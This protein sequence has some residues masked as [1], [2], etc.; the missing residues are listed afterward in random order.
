[1]DPAWGSASGGME[2]PTLF[3]G[4]TYLWAPPPLFSPESVTIHEA[5]HQF[6]YGLVGNNEF[7]EAW[8]DEGF[9]TYHTSKA[10]F[11]AL[12][13]RG[14]GHRYFGPNLGRGTRTGWPVM[15]P[16][17]WMGRGQD[18]LTAL[19][20][21]GQSDVMA[22]RA[23]EYRSADSYRVNSYDKPALTLQTLEALLGDETMTRILRTY[24]RR[25]R[26]AHPTTED[27]LATVNEVTGEDY[28]WFF[29]Q[30]FF[31]SDLCDYAITVE[32]KKQRVLEGF[33]DGPE[34][35]PV[36]VPRPGRRRKDEG[37]YDSVVTVS[38]LG[39]VRLPVEVLVEFGD[40]RKVNETWDGQYRW[41][42]F[43]YQSP[44]KVVRA[45]V[46]PE[47]K[48]AIDVNPANNSWVE[49]DGRARRAALKWSARWMFWLQNLLELHAI[50]G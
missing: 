1:V 2:Y 21:T 7:E 13:P 47:G 17:V 42:R 12:G 32:N 41:K 10:A 34:G 27:F 23:W 5:G 30:T 6:W 22:R 46:D 38:R 36:F 4:G 11:F 49:E 40:G 3:T 25:F 24:A 45:V 15:A 28:R 50:L 48:L 39:G 29:D 9:N 37:P 31:S 14:W 44:A 35:A 33:K 18:E 26:F 8:L 16:G 20:R 43:T 19:R